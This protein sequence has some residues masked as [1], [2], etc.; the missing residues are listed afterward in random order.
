[1]HDRRGRVW[2]HPDFFRCKA[3][4]HAAMPRVACPEHG[5]GTVPAPWAGP[6]GGFTLL[7]EAW[8]VEMAR[9]LPAGTLA[10]RLDET[11]T[12]LWRSVARCVDE[13]RRLEDYM[14]VEAVG[15]DG[16][17]RGGRDCITVV[18]D[19]VEHDVVNV[20]PGRDPATVERFSRGFMD[21]NGVPEYVRLVACDM[22]PGFR[23]GIRGHLPHAR[24]I[25]DRFHVAGHANEAVD[26]AGKTE[27]RSDPLLKRAE[28]LWLR[29]G[30]SLAELQV[31]A[32]R[33][34][35]GQRLKTGRACRMREVLQDICA[36]GRTPSEA[37][38]R[39]HRPCSWMMHS[40]LE[41]MKD[42]ARMVRRHFAEIVAY[43]GH[44]YANVVLEGADGVIRNVKRRARG[45]RDMDH[46][47]TM[48]YPTCGRLDLK[49]VTPT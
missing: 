33:S 30:E 17:G 19:L 34:L 49:A 39:L 7:F 26:K 2:R 37:W 41:P 11:G 45:F 14:G 22:S 20:T 10:G 23:K 46:S 29:D 9:H 12:R 8:A 42:F 24:R 32:R 31:E 3:F 15:I 47:A 36:D 1:M 38:V 5:V 43:F 48:I 27:G 13:A 21:R 16:T 4:I 18:A 40:R 44:P 25:V 28:Y 35:T 6:G